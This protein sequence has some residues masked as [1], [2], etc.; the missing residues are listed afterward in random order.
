MTLQERIK[1]VRRDAKLT[2][3]KFGKIIGLSEGSMTNIETGRDKPGEARLYLIA[4]K[5][6]V[7]PEWLINGI[8]EP[9]KQ[10]EADA[11]TKERIEREHIRRLFSELSPKTQEII[12]DVLREHVGL[13]H[14]KNNAAVNGDVSG[15]VI[16][17]QE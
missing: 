14:V 15:D 11:A 13:A 5:F 6:N 12:L 17:N 2:Q 9:Y 4:E 1:K 7:N 16:I 10:S 8:G 3:A